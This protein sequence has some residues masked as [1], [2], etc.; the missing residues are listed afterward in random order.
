MLHSKIPSHFK[1]RRDAL[2]QGHPG[3]VFLF[4]SN[5][6]YVRNSDVHYPYRQDSHFFYL[7]GFEEAE[8]FLV[9]AP[10]KAGAGSY[11]MI[12]FVLPR[13]PEKEMW[14]G[15][16][17]GIEGAQQVFG[18]DEVYPISELEQRLPGLMDA[19]DRVFYRM[20]HPQGGDQRVLVAMEK[21]RRALG[22]TGRALLP[23][24]DSSG[25]VGELRL[26]KGPDEI[27]TM[28]EVCRVTAQ[29]HR[30]VMQELRPKMIE[31]EIEALIDYQFRKGGCQRLGYGSIVAGGKNAACLHYRANNEALRDGDLVLIDAGGEMDYYSADI[32]RTFP[33]GHRFTSGQAKAYDLVLKAQKVG[34]VATRPGA[35]LPEIHK[36][37][38]EVMIDGLFS[39]GLAEGSKEELFKNCGFRR[40][41]PHGTSHWLGMDVHDVGLYLK[42]GQPRPLEPGMVFTVEP[43]FYVQPHDSKVPE[44]FR[45][46]GI[47]IEDDILVTAQGCE[48]LTQ[49]APK[50]RSELEALRE[51]F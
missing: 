8:S 18:A 47:R 29:A 41:F 40:F 46:L 32:T 1:A 19:G 15:E 9:L 16:R 3:G 21:H 38:C 34:I 35:T 27:E 4:P 12:L 14:E 31:S 42:D 33:I 10:K 2:V 45:H 25:P 26:F 36:Q 22:R 13:D 44:E 24:E 11:R 49:D 39:L 7:T 17:Y 48:N 28:R 23:I 51:R 20:G 30:T 37:V 6:D 43:G 50:E 5:P